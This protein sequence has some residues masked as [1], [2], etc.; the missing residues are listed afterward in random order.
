[1]ASLHGG[2]PAHASG[3]AQEVAQEPNRHGFNAST[4]ILTTS[5]AT[6]VDAEDL[7]DARGLF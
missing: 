7:G 4:K 3:F 5:S 6:N 2:D 1:L